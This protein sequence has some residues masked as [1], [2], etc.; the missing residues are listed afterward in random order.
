MLSAASESQRKA[1]RMAAE[2]PLSHLNFLRFIG[3]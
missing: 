1:S 3:C 2:I